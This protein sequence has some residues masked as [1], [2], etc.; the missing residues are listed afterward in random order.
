MYHVYLRTDVQYA[1]PSTANAVPYRI[2]LG[3]VVEPVVLSIFDELVAGDV[4]DGLL[5]RYEEKC[6]AIVFA[7]SLGP[8]CV[9][10]EQREIESLAARWFELCRRSI[11]LIPKPPVGPYSRRPT[12]TDS[13]LIQG[14]LSVTAAVKS[15]SICILRMEGALWNMLIV[16]ISWKRVRQREV[17]MTIVG[18]CMQLLVPY[19]PSLTN[20]RI[21]GV[22]AVM[23][24]LGHNLKALC[25]YSFPP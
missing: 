21:I 6:V 11:F 22:F 16:A 7:H 1:H 14:Q 10:N 19:K 4:F 18:H 15:A 25:N 23:C 5:L 13:V 24:H 12:R 20:V 2:V 17:R 3:A 8:R 9:W